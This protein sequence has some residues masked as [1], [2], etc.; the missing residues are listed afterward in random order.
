MCVAS[1]ASH[2][3]GIY[4]LSTS[5]PVVKTDPL[6]WGEIT[7]RV[8]C[9]LASTSDGGATSLVGIKKIQQDRMSQEK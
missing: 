7:P 9:L 2:Q 4:P 5:S 8:A 1:E 6:C 3:E